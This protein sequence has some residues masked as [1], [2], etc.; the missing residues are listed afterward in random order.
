MYACMRACW[1]VSRKQARPVHTSVR[2][3]MQ[4]CW[5]A[6][7]TLPLPAWTTA[8]GD[9]TRI[10][11]ICQGRGNADR[12]QAGE[13]VVGGKGQ[14]A[15]PGR[16]ASIPSFIPECMHS[17]LVRSISS[18]RHAGFR[19]ASFLSCMNE[20]R[21]DRSVSALRS[22]IHS[23]LNNLRSSKAPAGHLHAFMRERLGSTSS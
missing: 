15:F 20:R 9:E 5:A 1:Q 10:A 14:G 13:G 3:N 2:T 19:R 11:R 12:T 7:P 16:R 8:E 23:C 4:A 18:A 6:Q 21:R 17:A 22:G